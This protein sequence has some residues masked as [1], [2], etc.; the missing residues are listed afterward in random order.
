VKVDREHRRLDRVRVGPRTRILPF[1]NLYGC[2][3][4]A[5]C[6]VGPF[7]EIQED[8]VLGAR[9]RVQSHA[10]L[11]T[12]VTV[13][14]DAFIGHGVVFVNDRYPPQPDRGKWEG[15]RVGAGVAIGSNATILPVNIG[16]GA[17]VGAGSVVTRDVP[18]HAIVAGNPA[19]VIGRRPPGPPPAS[20]PGSRRASA[21]GRPHRPARRGAATRRAS[22]V[23]PGP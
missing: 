23:R 12:G 22:R 16:E 14:D 21:R 17:L 5:D 20:R 15:C 10:F 9:V 7:V 18:A 8:V 13:G 2:T 4:G 6:F 11:C 3:I 1:V 19:R